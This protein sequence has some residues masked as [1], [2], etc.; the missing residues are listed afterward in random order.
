MATLTETAYYTRKIISWGIVGIVALLVFRFLFL[1]FT[2]WWAAAHPPPPPPP[3]VTFGKL[4]TVSLPKSAAGA[5]DLTYNLQ[6][7]DGNTPYLGDRT[8]VY[9]MPRPSSNFLSFERAKNLANSLGFNG[10]ASELSSRLFVWTDTQI[11]YRT[12]QVDIISGNFILKYDYKSDMS[13]ALDK[14]FPTKEGAISE[15]KSF[16]DRIGVSSIDIL[17][18]EPKISFLKL[19][20]NQLTKTT[21]LSE[22]DFVRVD[23][24]RPQ[25]DSLPIYSYNPGKSLV[26]FIFSGSKTLNKR[27]IEAGYTYNPISFDNYA[28]YPIRSSEEAYKELT[29]GNGYV[30]DLGENN[31]KVNILK[32]YL[33][34]YESEEM[35]SYLQTV[36]VFEGEKGFYGYV[37]AISKEWLTTP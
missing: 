18:G 15:I 14:D 13:I 4:P 28:T 24:F 2:A 17:S 37:P 11:P 21:S 25:L 31:K 36:Y 7:V 1:G 16:F 6:T 27:F 26:Y 23:I 9:F 32:I 33:A 30:A 10:D 22:A 20:G 8:K 19:T 5:S 12:I 35:Q 34:Y 29:S 3:T